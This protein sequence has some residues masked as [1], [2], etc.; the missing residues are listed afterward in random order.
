M[1]VVEIFS[2]IEGEGKRAGAL[3][4]FIRLFGCNLRCSYCDTTYSY[5]ED[6]C[7]KPIIMSV[8]NIIH[9]VEQF[10]ITRVTITGGEPLIHPGIENLIKGLT[11][12]GYEVN[13]ET[14]GTVPPIHSLEH[15]PNLFYTYDFKCSSSGMKDKMMSIEDYNKLNSTDVLKFVVGTEQDME[16]ALEV[17]ESIT[18]KPIIY[19]S[20]VFNS[21]LEL[22]QIV[23]FIK[24]HN[25]NNVRFQIQ[26]HKVIWEPDAKGV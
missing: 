3:T 14:N 19:F 4:V 5:N 26:I 1:K 13:I 12:L 9:S 17:I 6:K 18:S 22:S 10:G 16:E 24:F 2:S 7:I 11:S 20:P 15:H 23:D 21:E 8:P 25:L